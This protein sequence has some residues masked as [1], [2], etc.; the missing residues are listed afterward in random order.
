MAPDVPAAIRDIVDRALAFERQRRWPDAAAMQQAVQ[1]ALATMGGAEP[2]A[3]SGRRTVM[4]SPTMQSATAGAAATMLDTARA[5]TSRIAWE[6][7]RDAQ[8]AE[9]TRTRAA[10]G[11]LTQ[12]YAAAKKGSAEALARL[13][14]VRAERGSLE[15][16]FTKQVGTRTAAVEEARKVVRVQMVTLARRAIGDKS[17]FGADYDAAREQLAKLDAAAEAARRDVEL[18]TR[19]L[20]AYDPRAMRTGIVLMGVA[21]ALLLALIIVP[22]VWRATMVET[23]QLP[24][25]PPAGQ[26]APH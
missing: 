20:A 18:H 21:A 11:D 9:A 24:K 6:K 16:Q 22:I 4:S 7:E 19:A 23:P 26:T 8:A 5:E 10:I 1:A 12:R 25:S 14:A 17:T 13:D 2:L 15:Q 3:V